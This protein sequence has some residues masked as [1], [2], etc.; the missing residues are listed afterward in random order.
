MPIGE[1]DSANR[2]RLG[3]AVRCEVAIE[4]T[5]GATSDGAGEVERYDVRACRL[6]IREV[7]GEARAGNVRECDRLCSSRTVAPLLARVS[8]VERSDGRAS[9]VRQQDAP[10]KVPGGGVARAD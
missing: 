5:S 3:R 2:E 6:K 8:N 9:V 4:R 7:S 1:I 10:E